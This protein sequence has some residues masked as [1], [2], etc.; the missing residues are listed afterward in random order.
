MKKLKILIAIFIM[1]MFAFNVN[2]LCTDSQLNNTVS[3]LKL[4]Y[5]IDKDEKFTDEN[6]KEYVIPH[7]YAYSIRVYPYSDKLKVMVKDS[8]TG[9]T[10]EA[11][12][13]KSAD[14]YVYGSYIH[15]SEKTYTI[16][17]YGNENSA[18]PNEL[19]STA[20]ITMPKFNEY[21]LYS[22]CEN[23]DDE[24]CSIVYDS[25]NLSQKDF[26]SKI[27]EIKEK[28]K[29]E[30][31]GTFK[32]ILYYIEKYWFFV[33]APVLVI[34]IIYCIKIFNHKKKVKRI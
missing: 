22:G 12:Y 23:V 19:I 28:N 15:Y 5:S 16:S 33:V 32:K 21:S 29:I 3:N 17:V 25:S 27:E 10:K 14:A 11:K 24:I 13:K 31:M 8:I 6:G 9:E 7:E 4:G 30:N 18:C 34:S 1:F 26:E 20:S 2:A